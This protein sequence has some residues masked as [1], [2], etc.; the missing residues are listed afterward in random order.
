MVSWL[1]IDTGG[2]VHAE[3][4][5]AQNKLLKEFDPKEFK[6]VNGRWELSKMEIRNV[7]ERS[8]TWL[9]FNLDAK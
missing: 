8:S 7:K 9:E 1:D 3:A 6:K 5:D 4:Y 2:I